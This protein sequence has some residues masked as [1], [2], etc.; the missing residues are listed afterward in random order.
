MV[1]SSAKSVRAVERAIDVL[2][3]FSAAAPE[4]S[5]TD[6]ERSL[7]LS[8]PTLYRLLTALERKGLVR[9]FGEPQ[10]FQL[11]YRV[12][13]LANVWLSD[14]DI[15]QTAQPTIESL[16]SDT[17]ETVAFFVLTPTRTKLCVREIP[18]RHALV[19]TRGAGFTEDLTTGSSG[20]VILAHLPKDEADGV[21]AGLPDKLQ[22][23][24]MSRDLEK[25]RQTGFAESEATI[26]DGAV[27]LAAP[28]FDRTGGVVGSIS[29][30]GPDT[31]ISG[32]RRDT[33][34]EKLCDAARR[35]S[36]TL[37]HLASAAE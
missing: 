19:F 35:I 7:K 8:R 34:I 11:D 31:R 1:E 32:E 20:R 23:K 18:S 25:I 12:V 29:L 26:L 4:L 22:R 15:L 16:W 28:V 21:M 2:L 10:R 6:L 14:N 30:F 17:N 13:E 24:A 27:A 9:S 33:C 3:S 36:A 37:G 5:V